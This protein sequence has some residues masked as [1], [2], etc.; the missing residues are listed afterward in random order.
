MTDRH[1]AAARK[2]RALLATQ[3]FLSAAELIRC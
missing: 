2:L 3:G 1:V